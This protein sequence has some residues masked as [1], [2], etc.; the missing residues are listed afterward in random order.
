MR[1]QN[2][3]SKQTEDGV[4]KLQIWGQWEKLK[5][6]LTC[7]L[8]SQTNLP[9]QRIMFEYFL[10]SIVPQKP[11]FCLEWEWEL[12]FSL[13]SLR[14]KYK[15]IFFLLFQVE[16]PPCVEIAQ[17]FPMKGDTFSSFLSSSYTFGVVQW[18]ERWDFESM[19]CL[20][21]VDIALIR[22]SLFPHHHSP[23][24]T[25][26]YTLSRSA[27]FA[28]YLVR[29]AFFSPNY[30]VGGEVLWFKRTI[31]SNAQRDGDV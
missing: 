14:E 19:V 10:F 27:Q 21:F 6:A 2:G 5:E 11:L 1:S 4:S 26:P 30:N 20:L 3:I 23:M 29:R 25:D 17:S 16:T 15:S 8:F 24:P 9:E 28:W 13:V 12:L 7:F 22:F 18:I 31:E